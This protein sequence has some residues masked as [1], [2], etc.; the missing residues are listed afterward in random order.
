MQTDKYNNLNG[1]GQDNASPW[2]EQ[3]MKEK[4]R[5]KCVNLAPMP[6]WP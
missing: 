3:Q 1:S 6:D 5:T 2:L 4:K